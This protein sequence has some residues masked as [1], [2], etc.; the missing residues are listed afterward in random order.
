MY[1]FMAQSLCPVT[2]REVRS[3]SLAMQ[4][5]PS[6]DPHLEDAREESGLEAIPSVQVPEPV[7]CDSNSLNIFP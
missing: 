7:N 4:D 3:H 1:R 2:T 6:M 5:I